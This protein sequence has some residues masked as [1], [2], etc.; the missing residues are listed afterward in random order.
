MTQQ[1]EIIRKRQALFARTG[2]PAL[3]ASAMML[4]A[5][6]GMTR[7]ERLTLAWVCQELERRHPEV[8]PALEAWVLD[9]DSPLSQVEAL[10]AAL[11]AEAVAA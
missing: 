3:L 5:L 1:T 4:D 9:L 8:T 6:T 7:E 10:I 11:P 2:T